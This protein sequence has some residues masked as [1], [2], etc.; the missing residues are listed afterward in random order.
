MPAASSK[1]LRKERTPTFLL[2]RRELK[3]IRINMVTKRQAI[4][5]AEKET[6]RFRFTLLLET[7]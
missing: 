5:G 6:W 7:W 2:N 4:P 3:W 1:D